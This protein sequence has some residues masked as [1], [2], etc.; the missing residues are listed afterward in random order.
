MKPGVHVHVHDVFYP[1]DY[2]RDWVEQRGVAWNEAYLLRAFLQ[3]N[4]RFEV[5]LFPDYLRR[6]HNRALRPVYPELLQ[7]PGNIWL[8][9]SQ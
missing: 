8:R 6:V 3:Y 5:R 4:D 9:R 2:P 1:F 7:W